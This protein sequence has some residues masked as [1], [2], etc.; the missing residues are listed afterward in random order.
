MIVPQFWAEARLQQRHQGKQV[1]VRR[2]GWSDIDQLDAQINAEARAQEAMA[3]VLAGEK[4]E[5]R[6]PK[7]PYH[8]AF[9]VPI[10]EEV[11]SRHGDTVITRNSYGAHCLNTPN[12]LFADIDFPEKPVWRVGCL[13]YLLMLVAALLAGRFTHSWLIGAFWVLVVLFVVGPLVKRVQRMRP[14]ETPDAE[15]LARNRVAEF[16]QGHPD[17]NLR[18][19]RTPAG[20]RVMATHKSFEPADPMVSTFFKA[21]GTDA[22]YALMCQNQQCFRARLSPKPWRMGIQKHMRPRPGTWPINPQHLPVRNEWIAHYEAQS[23]NWAACRFVETLGSG[24]VHPEVQEV[25]KLH[26]EMCRATVAGLP[27]A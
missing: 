10:R 21:L 16:A 14:D 6:E 20:L 8:G 15:T 9:G 13:A 11:L 23:Q 25:L 12:T 2:F 26:D 3:S 1:T 7:V 4:L 5:R 18:I 27:I 19:Y 24:V 17:W 22:I